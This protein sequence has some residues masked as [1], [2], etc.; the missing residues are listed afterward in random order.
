M[1]LRPTEAGESPV[2]YTAT[3]DIGEGQELL[4]DYGE[5]CELRSP[6]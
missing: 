5:R 1:R 2:V 6:W 4:V 3:K